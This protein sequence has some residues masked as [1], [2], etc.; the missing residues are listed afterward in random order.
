VVAERFDRRRTLAGLVAL[1]L[2][3]HI[4]FPLAG[5]IAYR[6]LGEASLKASLSA[7]TSDTWVLDCFGGLLSRDGEYYLGIAS[8]GYRTAQSWAFFPLYPYAARVLGPVLGGTPRAGLAISLGASALCCAALYAFTAASRGDRAA[9]RAVGLFLAFPTHFFFSAFYSESVYFAFVT[10]AFFSFSR[11]RWALAATFGALA[12]ATRSSGIL[13]LP[14]LALG[15]LH[16]ERWRKVDAQLAWLLLI[17]VGTALFFLLAFVKTG[18]FAA[19]LLAQELWARKT[20]FPLLTIAQAAQDFRL[21][22]LNLQRGLDCAATLGGFALAARSLR[23]L[24]TA[25]SAYLVLALLM[26]LSSGLVLSMARFVGA[27]PPVYVLLAQELV[28]PRRYALVLALSAM[29]Q[30]ALAIQFSTGAG[31]V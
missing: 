2:G 30:L 5:A 7:R 17:P 20:T 29:V 26:P 25:Q 18:T 22:P 1:F 4:G 24:D 8:D 28:Q 13:L 10:L 16:R 23:R 9:A 27:A 31:I 11:R 15:I 6:R 21:A 14:A 19:P 12:A 3:V